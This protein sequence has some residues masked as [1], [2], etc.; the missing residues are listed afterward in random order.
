VTGALL[1]FAGFEVLIAVES[2]GQVEALVET[3]AA[4]PVVCRP[5]G[6]IAAAKDPHQRAQANRSPTC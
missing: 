6:A 5:C 1:W 3:V 4:A 2:G